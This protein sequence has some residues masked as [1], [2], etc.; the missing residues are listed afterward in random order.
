MAHKG[1]LAGVIS[2][3]G[4]YAGQELVLPDLQV[5]TGQ[6]KS[7]DGCWEMRRNCPEKI[8]ARKALK[9]QWGIPLWS[10]TAGVQGS[11]KEQVRQG[12]EGGLFPF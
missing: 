8:P 3:Q 5:S 2:G 12:L 4:H 7:G 1:R 10:W 9:P 11:R 6:G